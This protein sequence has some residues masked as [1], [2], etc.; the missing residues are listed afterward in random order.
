MEQWNKSPINKTHCT[1][2]CTLTFDTNEY[3]ELPKKHLPKRSQNGEQK[4]PET[5]NTTQTTITNAMTTKALHDQIAADIK[6]DLSKF[7]S[8]KVTTLCTKIM[9]KI[10]DLSKSLTTDFNAQIAKVITTMHAL[11]QCFTEVMDHLPPISSTM[12]AH[13]KPKGLGITNSHVCN[14]QNIPPMG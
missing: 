1:N 8:I 10:T 11:N 9:A 3:P 13:K 12:P 5:G 6:D 4:L 14:I 2:T 7:I